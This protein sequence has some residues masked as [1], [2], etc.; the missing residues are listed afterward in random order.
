M[1]HTLPVKVYYEDTDMAGIVY[2]ANYLK[3]I[4]RGRSELI[5]E[6]GIDQLKMRESGL[7]FAVRRLEADYL[8]AARFGDDLVVHTAVTQVRGARI[9]MHQEVLRR[10][11]VIF[12]ADVTIVV[13]N[14]AGQPARVPAEIRQRLQ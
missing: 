13:I 7:V 4:E 5:A 2:Y 6:M 8:A 9:A 1:T 12:V 14:E 3:Y 11:D 10:K